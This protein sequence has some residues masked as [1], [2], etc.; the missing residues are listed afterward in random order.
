M[1][2]ALTV[3]GRDIEFDGKPVRLLGVATGDPVYGR[4]GR[5]V[6]DYETIAKEWK[7]NTVRFGIH[8]HLWKGRENQDAAMKGLER[9]V[10][11]TLKA[12]LFVLIDWHTIGWPD[13][14]YEIPKWEGGVKDQYDSG[15]A[16]CESFWTRVAERFGKEGRIGFELWNEPTRLQAES[17]GVPE[18]SWPRLKPYWLR[19]LETIRPR[20]KNLVIATGGAWAYDLRGV[21]NDLLKRENIAYAWHVYAGHQENDPKKWAAA[22]DDLPTAAPVI[23]TEWGFSR[24]AEGAHYKGT[25]EDFG[26]LFVRDFLEGRGLHSTA[27]CWHASWG[28]AM[29]EADWRTPT[30]FGRFV[31]DYL[32]GARKG[33]V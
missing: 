14:A 21:R 13:G 29:L 15:F 19:L 24:G 12:G 5:P 4:Q 22:L 7:A 23:V 20:S 11:A 33:S 1:A 16:L 30:E 10:E 3:S 28:P 17:Q 9:D 32:A 27:W 26:N 31:K 8:P 18:P 25:P 2:K 6:S